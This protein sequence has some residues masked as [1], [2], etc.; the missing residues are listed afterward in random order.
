MTCPTPSRHRR[1]R[2]AFA[3][4]V[5]IFAASALYLCYTRLFVSM[6][7]SAQ[8]FH[9]S[10]S[11]DDDD[12][13]TAVAKAH[14][15]PAD[16]QPADQKKIDTKP[17]ISAADLPMEYGT[18]A[19][20]PFRDL[21][22]HVGRVPSAH[23]PTAEN[24]QR[25]IIVGDVHG[26]LS[27]LEALLER[28]KFDG[29]RNDHLVLA[30][31]M[32]NKG[33]DSGGVIDLAMRVGASAVR[34][35][36][37]DRVLLAKR[38][39][40]ISHVADA[41]DGTGSNGEDPNADSLEQEVFSHGDYAD[42][43]TARSLTKQQLEWLTSLPVILH[44]GYVAGLSNLVVVHAG[45]VPNLSL[46]KQ[47]PWAVMNMRSLIYPREELR[48]AEA[49][50]FIE[51]GTRRRAE[52]AGRGPVGPAVG[53]APAK[54]VEKE[55]QKRKKKDDRRIAVPIDGREGESWAVAWNLWQAG[56]KKGDRT[57]VVYGHDAKNG[58]N[59]QEFTI[60]IDTGCQKGGKLTALVVEGTPSGVKHNIVQVICATGSKGG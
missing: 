7:L 32:V 29:G 22:H 38:G 31:D 45:L 39:M 56:L 1:R 46:D 2:R 41:V 3:L 55:Y 14:T 50:A 24:K 16:A 40:L 54:L 19:R 4:F 28:V 36:H 33:P 48:R 26:M 30:G 51:E 9:P 57:T 6:P 17:K 10:E 12:N 5:I 35:N 8:G 21:S 18:N 60:G 25:L 49:K 34:G 47:D 59:I 42:R 44:C 27:S 52:R 15:P 43:N 58:L 53:Q 23:V 20:P 37:E 13:D 11:L